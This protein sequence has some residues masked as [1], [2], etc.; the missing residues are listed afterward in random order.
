[1]FIIHIFYSSWKIKLFEL[2]NDIASYGLC[3]TI[4]LNVLKH[5]RTLRSSINRPLSEAGLPLLAGYSQSRS[6]PSKPCFLKKST[7]VVA[8]SRRLASDATIRVNGGDPM[9]QPPTAISCLTEGF[10]CF[11]AVNLSY[12]DK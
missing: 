3:Q 8:N 6:R 9:F 12:L 11:M 7:V 10:C 5:I 4:C 1:M 2:D